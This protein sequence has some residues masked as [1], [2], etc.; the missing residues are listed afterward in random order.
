M[1]SMIIMMI[2]P[3]RMGTGTQPWPADGPTVHNN[4][5]NVTADRSVEIRENLN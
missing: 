4:Y 1:A 3:A 2:P 5:R